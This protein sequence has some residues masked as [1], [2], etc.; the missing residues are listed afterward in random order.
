MARIYSIRIDFFC[1]D[2]A[3]LMDSKAYQEG[4]SNLTL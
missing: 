1:F 4:C 2:Q 3:T